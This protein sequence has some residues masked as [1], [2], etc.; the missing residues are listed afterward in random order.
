MT[1]AVLD[2]AT[3][4]VYVVM[5]ESNKDPEEWR[6]FIGNKTRKQ[7]LASRFKDNDSPSSMV[8]QNMRLEAAFFEIVRVLVMRLLYNP[9]NKK[10]SL[11]EINERINELLTHSVKSDGVITPLSPPNKKTPRSIPWSFSHP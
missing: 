6:A 1:Q 3:R 5:T 2:G 11:K 9:S 7:E 10:F 8:K 4:P